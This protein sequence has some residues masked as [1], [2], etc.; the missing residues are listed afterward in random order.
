MKTPRTFFCL[1]ATLASLQA[2]PVSTTGDVTPGPAVSPDWTVD[3]ELAVGSTGTGLLTLENGGTIYSDWWARLGHQA[4]SHGTVTMTGGSWTS[5][6]GLIIG[7]DGTGVFSLSGGEVRNEFT[8]LGLS[9]GSGTLTMEGGTWYTNSSLTVGESGTGVFNLNAGEFT[10]GTGGV[11]LGLWESGDGTVVMNGGTFNPDWMSI[12]FEGKGNFTLNGGSLVTLGTVDLGVAEGSSGTLTL[13]GGTLDLRDPWFQD[14]ALVVGS[15]GSGTLNVIGDT[16]I[17]MGGQSVHVAK[18]AGST[19]T[20]NFGSYDLSH[21]SAVGPVTAESFEIG[22]GTGVINFNQTNELEFSQEIYGTG[23]INQRGTGTT[24]LNVGRDFEGVVN[25]L[26]G[27]LYLDA[28]SDGRP[29]GYSEMFVGEAG[30]LAGRGDVWGPVVVEGTLAP[31]NL[32]FNGLMLTSTA[33]TRFSIAE[34]FGGYIDHGVVTAEMMLVYGGTLSLTL[35]NGFAPDAGQTFY[36]FDVRGDYSGAFDDIQVETEGWAATFDYATGGVSFT[37][38]AIPEPSTYAALV[39]ALALGLAA[40][41]R[42]QRT[43]V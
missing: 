25:V 41:R 16:S 14:D 34:Y 5:T 33:T 39:G 10:T 8:T 15:R 42:R 17:L 35:L 3:A 2:Q 18:Y 40:W 13:S 20:V 28:R 19:G 6:T 22:A 1:L 24:F 32:T 30:T 11:N 9:G 36:L 29:I 43:A 4:G 27:T 7:D 26:G 23:T 38:T 37:A 21:P 31:D 12:G